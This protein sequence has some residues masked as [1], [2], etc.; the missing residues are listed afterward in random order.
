MK[1]S[2]AF[3]RQIWPISFLLFAQA[4]FHELNVKLD[5]NFLSTENSSRHYPSIISDSDSNLEDFEFSTGL[6]LIDVVRSYDDVYES[7]HISSTETSRVEKRGGDDKFSSSEIVEEDTSLDEYMKAPRIQSERFGF[8]HLTSTLPHITSGVLNMNMAS[9]L[10]ILLLIY[11]AIRMA[12]QALRNWSEIHLSSTEDNEMSVMI[13]DRQDQEREREIADLRFKLE[14][15]VSD[16]IRYSTATRTAEEKASA[17]T[18]ISC[19]RIDEIERMKT[20]NEKMLVLVQELTDGKEEIREMKSA[21][22]V[23]AYKLMDS[24]IERDRLSLLVMELNKEREIERECAV[25]SRIN[26]KKEQEAENSFRIL[27][28]KSLLFEN[29]TAENEGGEEQEEGDDDSDFENFYFSSHSRVTAINPAHY[30]GSQKWKQPNQNIGNK[31]PVLRSVRGSFSTAVTDSP[32]ISLRND[33]CS[34]CFSESGEDRNQDD[35]EDELEFERELMHDDYQDQDYETEYQKAMR[36]IKEKL[37]QDLSV[38][39]KISNAKKTPTKENRREVVVLETAK[40]PFSLNLKIEESEK[41]SNFYTPDK[42]WKQSSS[43]AFK[44]E[45]KKNLG[46][47]V[48]DCPRTHPQDR[49][50]IEGHL[51]GQNKNLMGQICSRDEE[52]KE[53]LNRI[54]VLNTRLEYAVLAAK[55]ANLEVARLKCSS[56]PNT[57]VVGDGTLPHALPH[58]LPYDV[59]P[60]PSNKDT[61]VLNLF[62]TPEKLAVKEGTDPSRVFSAPH[63]IP[64]YTPIPTTPS[65]PLFLFLACA[66][67]TP[68]T[69]C[70][71]ESE[72]PSSSPGGSCVGSEGETLD[73]RFWITESLEIN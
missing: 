50:L 69:G 68:S 42:A 31:F 67:A 13:I 45:K 25:D 56:S 12:V 47:N 53:S 23:W 17:D 41:I 37:A 35:Y 6:P 55:S 59:I 16:S 54:D 52:I 10:S 49:G 27:R 32:S 62:T 20:E 48:R 7:A 39:D 36:H 73:H 46:E 61:D 14:I 29:G 63:D 11:L 18:R 44:H 4:K 71:T 19:E 5:L 8:D 51:I 70:K 28:K 66:G 57:T 9:S 1:P 2:R 60:T 72:S 34:S 15:A 3:P 30:G 26:Q 24:T 65:H 21:Q 64:P 43:S 40:I 58:S 33:S 38:A 22:E